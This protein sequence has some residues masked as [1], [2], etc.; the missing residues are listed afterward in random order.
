MIR[1]T[2][3]S[4]LIALSLITFGCSKNDQF[5]VNGTISGGEGQILYLEYLGLTGTERIDSIKLTQKGAFE[6]AEPTPEYPDFYRL[7]LDKQIIPFAVD[8]LPTTITINADSRSFATNYSIIGNQASAQIRDVWLALLDA[9]VAISKLGRMAGDDADVARK[10]SIINQYKEIARQHIYGNPKS[11][12][13]YFALFQQVDGN[14]VFNLYDKEDSKTFGAVANVYNTFQPG[15]PRSQHLYELALRSIAVVRQL[16]TDSLNIQNPNDILNKS[17]IREQG[18]ID[19]TL[20]NTKG[21]PVSLSSIV[22]RSDVLLAFTTME[23]NW[24]PE[25]NELLM[26]VY[27]DYSGNG[28]EVIQVGLDSDIH[29]WTSATKELPWINLRDKDGGYSKLVG[30][31]N[32]SRLPS[33]FVIKKGGTALYRVNSAEDLKAVI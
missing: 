28:V 1:K 19:F 32:L 18:Y 17:D 22:D 10:D 8:T 5:K 26:Q 3:I 14:L 23:A 29:I 13:A 24:A 9:N 33:L 11:P 21:E 27:R 12:V 15:N 7:R 30:L 6:F 16:S 31:Y 2:I 20:P 4:T 25:L